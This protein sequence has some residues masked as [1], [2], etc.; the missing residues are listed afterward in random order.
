MRLAEGDAW[1]AACDEAWCAV[2]MN[3]CSLGFGGNG[4]GIQV[5]MG[6]KKLIILFTQGVALSGAGAVRS[7]GFAATAL[8]RLI[9]SVTSSFCWGFDDAMIWVL[10]G[11]GRCWSG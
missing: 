4:V 2:L 8:K 9:Q 7:S 5:S 6:S 1:A 3:G 11:E 10:L